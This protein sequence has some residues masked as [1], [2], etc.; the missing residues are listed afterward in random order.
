MK[1]LYA[2]GL[3]SVPSLVFLFFTVQSFRGETLPSGQFKSHIQK[4][5]DRLVYLKNRFNPSDTVSW[6]LFTSSM[7]TGRLS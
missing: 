7:Q 5:E 3:W 1:N 4:L 2:L 6:E